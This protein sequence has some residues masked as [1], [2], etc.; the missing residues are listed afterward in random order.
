[1]T[2]S[3]AADVLNPVMAFVYRANYDD[4]WF[5]WPCD[6]K[7]EELRDEFARATDDGMQKA[8]TEATQV[9]AME[10]V[11]HAHASQYFR[12]AAY[13]SDHLSGVIEG[14]IPYFCNIAKT[15]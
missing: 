9:R 7:M 8:L 12:P 1:M 3:V 2:T 13:R 10:I 11:T 5:G 15:E 6:A 14:P 4:A